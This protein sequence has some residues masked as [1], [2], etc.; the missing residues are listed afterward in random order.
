MS[1]RPSAVRVIGPLAP[2]VVGFSEELV[3][4][5]Y[6][7]DPVC[8]Q[9]RLM[10]HA[11]RWLVGRGLGADDLT[12]ERVEEF[13]ADRRAEGYRLWLSTKAMVPMLGYLRGLGV[14]PMAVPAALTTERELLQARFETYLIQERGLAAGTIVGYLHVARLFLTARA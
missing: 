5:G 11:S 1:G 13:L 6:R 4:Q 7:R 12:P 9:L 2:H 14:V 8:D 3:R 10:A